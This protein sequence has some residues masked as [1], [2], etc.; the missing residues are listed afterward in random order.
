MGQYEV[1][2]Q[3]GNY[4]LIRRIGQ[5]G[6]ARVYLG[7]HI[8]LKSSVALKVLQL[9]LDSEE[10]VNR[11]RQEAQT[12]A[13]LVHPN[14]VRVLDFDVQDDLAFLV[15]D[16]APFGS[17]RKQ[18]PQGTVVPLPAIVSYVRQMTSALSYAH[19]HRVIHRDVKP[20]NMLVGRDFS[21]LLS[22]FGLALLAEHSPSSQPTQE[23][24]GTIAYIAPEQIRGKPR[25]ASDQYSLAVMVYE[26][27]CG[28]R[29]FT[30]TMTEVAAKHLSAPPPPLSIFAP[31]ISPDLEQV[32]L[33][34]LAKEPARR[35]PTVLDFAEALEDAAR[36]EPRP[37]SQER[38]SSVPLERQPTADTVVL[39]SSSRSSRRLASVPTVIQ[40]EPIMRTQKIDRS[41]PSRRTIL[42]GLIALL[43]AGGVGL[44]LTLEQQHASVFSFSHLNTVTPQAT[45]AS[46]PTSGATTTPTNVATATP[47]PTSAP[48]PTQ[49]QAAANPTPTGTLVTTYRGHTNV[50]SSVAWSP[51]GTR[52]ASGGAD[53]TA[54]VWRV[55]DGHLI[56][57][58]TGHSASVNYVAWSPDGKR[59]ASA[60]DDKTVH[61]WDAMTGNLLFMCLGHTDGV[62]S[63]LW[64]PDGKRIASGSGDT[65]VRVWDATNGNLL[66]SY[67]D[68][69][70]TVWDIAWSPDGTRIASASGNAK[71]SVPDHTIKVWDTVTGTTTVTYTGHSDTAIYVVWSL[72]GTRI[73]SGSVDTTVQIWD[74]ATGT[75][76]L[77]YRGHSNT[78]YGVAWSPGGERVVSGSADATVAIWDI[79]TNTTSFIYRGHS[80][81][82]YG[83]AWSPDGTHIASASN[84]QTVQVWQ[85]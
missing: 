30:G 56:T 44:A 33:K 18:Y 81:Y 77:S 12:I 17:L 85:A 83:V 75:T 66:L 68:H 46:A 67:S 52:I 6:F 72:D 51:D 8:H 13:E 36:V 69:T 39:R 40:K 23:A 64:S 34:A 10:L 80:S 76:Q 82:V 3:L 45:H 15:M 32:V 50:V 20:E 71:A 42:F 62:H 14:I 78:V 29:P 2:A 7:R 4:R 57:S 5:G 58:Y 73:A 65:S 19:Q 63:V 59:V 11:F 61:V 47:D 9:R 21:I 28:R 41:S 84:D 55:G 26:W 49:A 38:F 1:P 35:F 27:L 22:D 16:Y 79:T 53:K 31:T 25:L 70:A 43:S 24:A 48:T 54:Q 37:P 60:S 74:A